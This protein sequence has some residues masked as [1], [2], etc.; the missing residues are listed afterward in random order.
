MLGLT[1][2]HEYFFT[3]ESFSSSRAEVFIEMLFSKAVFTASYILRRITP[4]PDSVS[5][6]MPKN[7]TQKR[8]NAADIIF[9]MTNP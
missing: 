4:K 1:L 2:P 6:Q 7:K 8:K 9:L 3:A 5:S